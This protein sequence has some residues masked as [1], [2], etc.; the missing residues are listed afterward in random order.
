MQVTLLQQ[1]IIAN[2]PQANLDY[3]A[4]QMQA[5][6]GS[7]LFVLPEL[8]T[9]GYNTSAE[10]LADLFTP[11]IPRQLQQL[12]AA[13]QAAICGS[14]IVRTPKGCR[15]RH[16]FVQPDGKITTYDKHHL[17]HTEKGDYTSGQERVVV[18]WKGVR[19]LLQVC[20]DLRFPVWARN[21]GEYDCAIYVANWPH[22]R[23]HIWNTLLRA[24][25]IENQCFVIGV[26]RVG[27]D[28]FG[29]YYGESALINP[30]GHP[31]VQST[32]EQA[33]ALTTTLDMSLLN[34]FRRKFP[35]LLD[36]DPFTL[37]LPKD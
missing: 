26:N 33:E 23:S 29:T 12:S 36:G 7:E 10:N 15:N 3:L 5:A 21:G 2:N 27:S 6:P 20:F 4:R 24:R 22:V 19:F 37:N 25:A 31:V 35:I 13:H 16:F 14:M 11:D 9:T 28:M 1:D 34:E 30:M 17:Y 18:E 32:S 8:F